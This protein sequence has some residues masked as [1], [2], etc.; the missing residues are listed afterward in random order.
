MTEFYTKAVTVNSIDKVHT[1]QCPNIN[2]ACADCVS[3]SLNVN[4]VLNVKGVF[5]TAG[6]ADVDTAKLA[7]VLGQA[8][9]R[10][11]SQPHA[12]VATVSIVVPKSMGSGP[13][14]LLQQALPQLSGAADDNVYKLPLLQFMRVLLALPVITPHGTPA[15][16]VQA[17][18]YV[19]YM[20]LSSHSFAPAVVP[21]TQ[22]TTMTS[23]GL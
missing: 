8:T 4:Q 6:A 20:L 5:A 16:F 14:Q 2:T 3:R 11:N 17:A 22:G 12:A 23:T 10:W 7:R 9:L 15:A 1:P 19:A 18:C 21:I 13:R